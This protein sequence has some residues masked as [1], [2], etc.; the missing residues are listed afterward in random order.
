MLKR[1]LRLPF[2]FTGIFNALCEKAH[3]LF[4]KIFWRVVM[5]IIKMQSQPQAD[6]KVEF[7]SIK[8]KSGLLLKQRK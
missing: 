3:H 4:H 2:L 6:Y 5:S 1:E 8:F 7:I